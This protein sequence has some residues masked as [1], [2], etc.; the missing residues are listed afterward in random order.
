[1]SLELARGLCGFLQESPVPF[2]AVRAIT[3]RLEES[4]Y[5]PL[6]ESQPWSLTPGGRYYVT[7]NQSSVIAFQ[8]GSRLKDYSFHIA[9]AHS[10][11][12]TFKLKEHAV[13]EVRGHYAQ[14]NTEGYGG[15]L[16]AS[17]FDR[18]LSLAGRV[19]VREGRRLT[20]RLVC[21]D[22]DLLLIPSVAIHMNREANSGMAYNKQVDLL[23]L[24]GGGNTT[25]ADLLALLAGELGVAP[26]AICAKDLYLYNRMAP[27]IWGRRQEFLSA[28]RLDDLQCAY[29]ALEGLRQAEAHPD[30]AAVY[31]VFD[32]EEVGS[33]TKHGARSTFLKDTLRRINTALG[34]TEEDYLRAVASSLMLSADNAH[35]VHPNHPEKSD[36]GNCV[37]LNE[38]VV[39]KSH[40]GQQYTSDGVSVALCRT[41]CQEAGVPFQFFSNR[42][43]M[44]GGSTLGNLSNVQVS[45]N[46]VDVGLPQ[47]AM[48]SAYETAGVEDTAH[49]AALMAA[50]F[51]AHLTAQGDGCYSLDA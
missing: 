43:D 30:T 36:V 10:D 21:V 29:A 42:S 51:R 13:V 17:W 14:L 35:A 38:G 46:A 6:Q 34:K 39:I 44:T 19:L 20:A 31:A 25:E 48:H 24:F 9:A 28:P 3:R 11:S 33:L 27:T 15:M 2:H 18:P 7:R 41:L 1:M 26:E 8:L 4:G 45:L 50:F 16:C 47:L 49:M 5:R 37:Y 23:P 40:A 12:P 22:R 32:N